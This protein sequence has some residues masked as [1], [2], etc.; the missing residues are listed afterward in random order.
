MSK[1]LKDFIDSVDSANKAQSNLEITIRGL[2]EDV[3][4]LNFTID[5]QKRIIED[6]KSKL[7][8][9]QSD[10]IPEDVSVLKELVTQQRQDI[11]KKDKD[12]EILQHT[13][14]EITVELEKVQ[15]YEEENEELI[16]ANKEIVQL[17]E[18]NENF[19]IE[20]EELN[21]AL[22][23]L[24]KE[25]GSNDYKETPDG[26]NSDL[27][28]AKKLIIKFTEE[29][30][31]HRVQIE[32]LK[33]EIEI[34]RKQ[35]QEN[36]ALKNQFSHELIETNKIID[37]LTYDNDQYHEKV[38]YMQ[39][40]LEETIKL[41]ENLPKDDRDS[42]EVENLDK[43]LFEVEDENNYLKSLV[44]T[45]SSTIENL[46]QRN[47]EMEKELG[48]K[49]TFEDQ[50]IS[51]LQDK[52]LERDEELNKVTLTL[53]KIENANKQLS[54]LIVELKVQEDQ[55]GENLEFESSSKRIVY[56]DL[57]PN[58][59]FKMYRLLSEDDKTTIVNQLIDDLNSEIR[60]FRTYAIK[61][62]SVIKGN[63]VFEVL[64][65]IINDE[66]WIVK[67]YLI[68]A[69]RNFNEADTIPLLKKLLEDKDIDVREAAVNMLSEIK[70]S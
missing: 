7:S 43:I 68:K 54:D 47:I 25:L 4:R 22:T 64:K 20:V 24:Q 46:K 8:N 6:Q 51:D 65:D 48:E 63:R 37:Q 13:I 36:E 12:V 66:D 39:Q 1:E 10:N 62:L 9:I 5:E 55:K 50:K 11:I 56:E 70:Q 31:I 28:D 35:N 15:K 53:Q 61:V 21:N 14:A 69:F 18:E 26:E 67:L 42:N 17:T 49:A 58:L 57:P 34:Q 52:I 41:Q 29:N 19:R 59:F 60:D 45:N 3:Q 33:Q 27:L 23:N 44:K 40:K 30:G 2:K 38:N 16:Y 32:S